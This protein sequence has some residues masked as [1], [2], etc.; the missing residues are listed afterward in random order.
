MFSNYLTIAWRNL[1][2]QPFYTFIFVSGLALG[3]TAFLF[4]N[5][6]TAFEKSYDTFHYQP[7]QLYRLT[8]DQYTGGQI[9][10]RDAMSHAPAGKLLYDAF[11][12]VLRYTTT[13]KTE[14]LVFRKQQQP[15]EELDVIAVDEHFLDLFAYEVIEGNKAT[16]LKEPNSMV[17][18]ESQAQKYFGNANPMGQTIDELDNFNE[19]FTVTGIIRDI[20]VNTHYHFDM[21]MSFSS[22]ME[23]VKEDDWGG[24]NYYTY[25]LLDEQ[26]Q[27]E[28]MEPKLEELAREHMG[29]DFQ[30]RFNLQP[31]T[32]IHLL[33]DFT[34]EPQVHGSAKAVKF[35]GIISIFILL[36]AWVNYINLSTAKAIERAKEVGLRKV[37]GARRKQLVSQFFVESLLIN[38][39]GA[40]LAL[41]LAFLLAP[42]FNKLLGKPVITAVFTNADFLFKLGLFFVLGTLATGI[43]P[44]LVLSSFLPITALRGSFARSQKGIFMRKFLVVLQFTAS[45]L[46][47]A[48]TLIIYRQVNYMSSLEMGMNTQQ[49]LGFAKPDAGDFSD[50]AY[51]SKI[52]AFEEQLLKEK[53]IEKIGGIQNMPGGSGF[54]INSTSGGI[55][56]PG[57]SDFVEGTTYLTGA[58]DNYFEVLDVQLLAG[59]NFDRELAS[60][61]S[62]FMVNEAFLRMLNITD[63]QQVVGKHF[64]IGRDPEGDKYPIV[65]VINDFNRSS[66]KDVV[67]PTIFYHSNYSPNWVVKLS[68]TE[69]AGSIG[70]I[71]QTFQQFF[72]NAPF[73]YSFLDERFASIYAEDKRFGDLFLYFSVLAIFVAFMGLF[74]LSSYLALQRAREVGIRKVLGASVSSIIL[75]FFRDFLHLILIAVAIGLPLTYF[76]MDNWLMGYAHR[77]TFPWWVLGLAVIAI[78]SLA[79]VSVSYQ[80]WKLAITNPREVIRGD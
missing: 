78:T 11:P 41:G 42:Y 37:V 66:L 15:V 76:S 50:E 70:Y 14:R 64:Q 12:E 34:F 62:A 77:I 29:D 43:Y 46:L 72:P 61:S 8:T 52:S 1:K 45:L 36:I 71:Q 18:T 69:I 54:D 32:A 56:I 30:F 47:I 40:A 53:G 63:P 24:Y 4:L 22:Y 80:S 59:R 21:L 20:P 10:V 35:L 60:D 17:L 9:A 25:L 23:D 51:L 6:Y 49:V 3:L 28:K 75:L 57:V 67:E 44:A 7:D 48:S 68:S 74:G 26:V 79:F 33:S 65:G 2:R 38:L 27:L 13:Y 55:Q 5:Q 16:M 31:V 58:D 39:F 73:A 19:S